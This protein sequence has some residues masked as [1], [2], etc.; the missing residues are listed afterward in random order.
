MA[1]PG[2]H[3]L[4]GTGKLLRTAHQPDLFP[5]MLNGVWC[6]LIW[7]AICF[8]TYANKWFHVLNVD[9]CVDICNTNHLGNITHFISIWL[10]L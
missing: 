1:H 8:P 5:Q 4:P 7:S 9:S 10:Q 6:T 2:K 3:Q